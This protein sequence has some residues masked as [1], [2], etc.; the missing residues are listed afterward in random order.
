M[1][2]NSI[3]LDNEII[4]EIKSK[5]LEKKSPRHVPKHI[6]NLSGLPV[7][8]SGKPVE[9]SVKAV[10]AGKIAANK[11]VLENPEILHEV[12]LHREK[13]LELYN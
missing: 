6:F 2:N 10:L 11:N 3:K 9:L 7:T 5:I 12:E 4:T 1:L 8:R 13:L